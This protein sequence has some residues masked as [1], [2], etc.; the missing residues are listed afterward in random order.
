MPG[1]RV[2]VTG[3]GCVTPY[4]P[5]TD[6]FWENLVAGRSGIGHLTAFD[7]K[8]YATKVAGQ[9]R[10]FDPADFLSAKEASASA[11]SVQFALAS[12]RM[13]LDDARLSL[14]GADTGRVG[15]FIGSSAGTIEYMAENHATFLEKGIRRVHPMF[16]ALSYPGVVATQLAISLG[17]RGPVMSISSACTSSTD[18][19]GIA[20]LQ[21]KAGLID[22]AIVGGTEAPL[23]P[24]LYASF[25]RLGVMS[26]EPDPVR[27]SRPFATD[28][29]GFVL[30]EGAGVCVLEAEERA[31]ERGAKISAEVAGYGATSDGFH[32]F[33]ASPDGTEGERAIAI[34]LE[35]GGVDPSQ[36]DYVSAHAVGSRQNDPIELDLLEKVFVGHRTAVLVSSI[37]S[38]IGHTMGAAGALQLMAAIRS[39]ENEKLPGTLNLASAEQSPV[40]N[41]LAAGSFET[42]VRCTVLPTFGFGSRNAAL[43]LTSY[44]R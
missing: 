40:L 25:D 13:A 33:T 24:I 38:M 18:A 39:I 32:P 42:A 44:G 26:R 21:I 5:G 8:P 16:P 23:S 36:V 34:A 15:V 3:M 35:Q 7:P 6:R 12:A 31:L 4:G 1:G 37:K 11:R 28:R 19:I 29:D 17:V 20:W 41:L 30:S 10:D 14:K 43:V 9:V 27:A 2:V 22:C